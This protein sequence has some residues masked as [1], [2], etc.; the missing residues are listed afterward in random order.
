MSTPTNL[1]AARAAA[2]FTSDLSAKEEPT[3]V[4]VAKAIRH[5]VRAY[6]GIR[7]CIIEI[8]GEYGD[9][10]EYAA[11]RM[12]WALKTIGAFYGR[13]R[14]AWGSV[15]CTRSRPCLPCRCRTRTRAYGSAG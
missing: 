6:G 3:Q 8:A 9:H 7:G 13:P 2:L 15:G 4:E 5:A 11:Y 1:L 10:P 14:R 12:R